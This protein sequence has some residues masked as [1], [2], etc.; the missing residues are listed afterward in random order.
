MVRRQRPTP[1]T[2]AAPWGREA[3]ASGEVR[4]SR[5]LLPLSS[6]TYHARCLIWEGFS[7]RQ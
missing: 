1:R 6:H 4:R 3:R 7:S 2:S 5:G